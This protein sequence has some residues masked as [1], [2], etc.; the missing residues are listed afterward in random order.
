MPGLMLLSRS[1]KC[2][3]HLPICCVDLNGVSNWGGGTLGRFR[4]GGSNWIRKRWR[5]GEECVDLRSG[6]MESWREEK[7]QQ[8]G[9]TPLKLLTLIHDLLPP[10]CEIHMFGGGRPRRL[11]PTGSD[12]GTNPLLNIWLSS[13]STGREPTHSVTAELFITQRRSIWNAASVLLDI[14]YILRLTQSI[15]TWLEKLKMFPRI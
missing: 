14:Q 4:G 12:N 6:V 7:E 3:S 15:N 5:G 10:R 11:P 8:R 2:R 1:F 9:E 13:S